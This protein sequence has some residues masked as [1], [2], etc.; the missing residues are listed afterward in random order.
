VG[1]GGGG[2]DTV[3]MTDLRI[4]GSRLPLSASI[5]KFS[6]GRMK[7]RCTQGQKDRYQFSQLGARYSVQW[8]RGQSP[9]SVVRGG[10]TLKSATGLILSRLLADA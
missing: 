7:S 5:A 2:G 8:G 10:T 4:R 9:W 3:W 6:V 1:D